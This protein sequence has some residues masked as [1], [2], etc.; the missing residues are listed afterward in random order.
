MKERNIILTK[1]EMLTVGATTKAK[2]ALRVNAFYDMSFDHARI[3]WTGTVIKLKSLSS[4][5]R[6]WVNGSLLAQNNQVDLLDND[7]II[8]GAHT[9]CNNVKVRFE[10]QHSANLEKQ[11]DDVNDLILANG[12]EHHYHLKNKHVI[13]IGRGIATVGNINGVHNLRFTNSIV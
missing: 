7:E 9:H 6:T 2:Q 10:H 13:A 12:Q 4:V 5:Y 1:N 3:M 8:F 11:W